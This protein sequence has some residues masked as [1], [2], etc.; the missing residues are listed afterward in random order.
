MS[1]FFS[2]CGLFVIVAALQD[3]EWFFTNW[4]AALVVRM[5]GR[6]GARLFYGLF[7]VAFLI[8]GFVAGFSHR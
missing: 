1:T 4:R 6:G 8:V 7:G 5:F 3:W 2:V